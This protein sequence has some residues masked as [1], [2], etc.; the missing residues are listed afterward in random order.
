MLI[1]DRSR[2]WNMLQSQI[3]AKARRS[4]RPAASAGLTARRLEAR[5][6]QRDAEP[7]PECPAVRQAHAPRKS[8]RGSSGVARLPGVQGTRPVGKGGYDFVDVVTS[9]TGMAAR[10]IRQSCQHLEERRERG[11]DQSELIDPA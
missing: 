3:A 6:E 11:R 4:S 5:E 10:S 7:A 9:L 1:D 8:A 2:G